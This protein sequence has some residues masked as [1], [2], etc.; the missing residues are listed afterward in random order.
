[1]LRSLCIGLLAA[2]LSIPAFADE[3]ISKVN[4][5]I[6]VEGGRTV[7]ELDTV[8]GS[9]HLGDNARATSIETVNGS[10]E[11]GDGGLHGGRGLG[12][13]HFGLAAISGHG[14]DGERRH[15]QEGIAG[16]HVGLR[17]RGGTR[18]GSRRRPRCMS[19]HYRGAR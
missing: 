3:D 5:S 19:H 11:I 2:G 10:I 16:C 7:G 13:R 6:R 12:E 18:R 4:G 17:F 15:Q 8:N 14:R 9:I 1:M